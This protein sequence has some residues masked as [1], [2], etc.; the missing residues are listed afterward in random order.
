[1]E[2]IRRT[3][4]ED[5]TRRDI[6]VCTSFMPEL[7]AQRIG[8]KM[9]VEMEHY[10]SREVETTDEE[11]QPTTATVAGWEPYCRYHPMGRY[12]VPRVESNRYKFVDPAT[13]DLVPQGTE[14]AVPEVLAI[15]GA[16]LQGFP[17]PTLIGVFMERMIARG[18]FD[19]LRQLL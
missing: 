3:I 12:E 18:N 9:H 4:F 6:L 17:V 14:G 13:F 10:V 8:V 7:D 5:S 1:M 19:D 2:P 16:M 11:G 15:W